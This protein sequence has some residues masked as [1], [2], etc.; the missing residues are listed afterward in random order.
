MLTV[1]NTAHVQAGY[2]LDFN[3]FVVQQS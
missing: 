2:V 1:C 3:C